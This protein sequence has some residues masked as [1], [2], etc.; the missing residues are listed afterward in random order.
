MAN[1]GPRRVMLVFGTRPEAVKMAP[2][3]VALAREPDLAPIVT[4]TAQH[5]AMLD[6]VLDAFGLVTHFDLNIFQPGQGLADITSRALTS[7]DQVMADVR[8]DAV[9]VQGDT[10]TTFAGALCGFYHRIPVVHLEAGLRTGLLYSPYPEEINRRLTGQLS[11]MHLAATVGAKAN[12]L[13]EGVPRD[14]IIV[15]GN[16][17]VD[18]LLWVLERSRQPLQ[19]ALADLDNERGQGAPVLLVTAHRRESWGDQMQSIGRALRDI[20]DARPDV[21]VVVPLHPNP[22]VR[23]SIVPEVAG[24]PN[25]R[26]VEPLSYPEFAVMLRRAH[27]VLTDSGGV[28]EEAP[29]LH[30]PVLI[31]RETTERP[32]A[33]AAGAAKL[34][35]TNSARITDE[36]LR[37][38]GSTAAL[39]AMMVAENPFGDGHAASRVVAALRY[40]VSGG[41]LPPDF[42]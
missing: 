17:V 7:L 1:N 15:T 19:P 4:V 31:M 29:S 11:T 38:L 6:Q 14:R 41:S 27:L 39:Q 12:L 36:V 37:L 21:V 30:T 23:G 24:A 10:T 22:I 20:A 8:P 2:V 28:Q 40:V 3:A 5:R 16:T 18:A 25:I 26:L 13:A 9:L 34:V 33:I 32:E 35:G 42:A